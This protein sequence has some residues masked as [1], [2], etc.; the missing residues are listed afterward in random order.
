MPRGGNAE[1]SSGNGKGTFPTSGNLYRGKGMK[2]DKL[3][4]IINT[5]IITMEIIIAFLTIIASTYIFAKN[6]AP[7]IENGTFTLKIN[8]S[9][10]SIPIE[11]KKLE[12]DELELLART[13]YAEAGNQGMEGKRLVA[14]V[15][16][17]R[18]EADEFPSTIK[19]VI[20][21]PGQFDVVKNRTIYKYELDEESVEAC[22]LEIANRTS[23]EIFYFNT[24]GFKK[25]KA[26]AKV[27]DHYFSKK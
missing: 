21:A 11:I 4:E 25:G 15:I 10:N 3:Y 8:N 5:F 2:K 17:N 22:R 18:A 1:P 14:A 23:N 24:K 16:L 9:E 26:W 20:E 6:I 13:V 19:E 7:H 12:A 27:G